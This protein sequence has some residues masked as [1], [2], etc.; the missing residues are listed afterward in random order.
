MLPASD[1]LSPKTTTCEKGPAHEGGDT[2]TKETKDARPITIRCIIERLLVK[3]NPV[4]ERESLVEEAVVVKQE[5]FKKERGRRA[6]N[7]AG[8]CNFGGCPWHSH[9]PADL[10]FHRAGAL[11]SPVAR[12]PTQPAGHLETPMLSGVALTLSGL[13]LGINRPARFGAARFAT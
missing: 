7:P 2:T 1:R 4:H 11:D 3:R 13:P 6:M 12:T 10:P 5:L 8:P 9:A